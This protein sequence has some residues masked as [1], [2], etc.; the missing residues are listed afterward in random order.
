MTRRPRV[1]PAEQLVRAELLQ[2]SGIPPESELYRGDYA[3]APD[4]VISRIANVL[5]AS[6]EFR[7]ACHP[8]RF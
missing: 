7:F 5:V 3:T 4:P 1:E 8:S 6:R 2:R